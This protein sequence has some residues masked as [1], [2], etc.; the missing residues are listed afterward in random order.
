M[1]GGATM[2]GARN[3]P[4]HLTY[5][6][7]CR[8]SGSCRGGYGCGCSAPDV[9]GGDLHSVDLGWKQGGTEGK[10]L[11]WNSVTGGIIELLTWK[12]ELFCW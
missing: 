2:S 8:H 4:S 10:T 12:L 7:A 6:I 9:S 5:Y 11:N 3:L 1:D